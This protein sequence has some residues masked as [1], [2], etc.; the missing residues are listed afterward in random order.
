MSTPADEVP[1][2]AFAFQSRRLAC[3]RCHR[4]KLKCERGSFILSM[5]VATPLGP[6]KRCEKAGVDC[7]NGNATTSSTLSKRKETDSIDPSSNMSKAPNKRLPSIT[8]S[9]SVSP[10][11]E[12]E[13]LVP[14]S[15][16][17]IDSIDSNLTDPTLCLDT[18][19]FDPI[20]IGG[21][22]IDDFSPSSVTIQGLPSPSKFHT[23]ASAGELEMTER[24]QFSRGEDMVESES[25]ISDLL[26]FSATE[27]QMWD[28]DQLLSAA[29]EPAIKPGPTTLMQTLSKLSELQNF[30]F[31]DLGSISKD[32][33]ANAF[34]HSGTRSSH[35]PRTNSRDCD[36]VGKVLQASEYLIDLLTSCA[37]HESP[38]PVP[39]SPSLLR[40][41]RW[42]GSK[43]SQSKYSIDKDLLCADTPL[44]DS[45]GFIARAADTLTTHLDFLRNNGV[46]P[47]NGHPLPSQRRTSNPKV[48]TSLHSS[49]LSPAKLMLLVCYVSLLSVYRSILTSA[50]EIFQASPSPATG[51]R[52]RHSDNTSFHGS[53]I[54][55]QS[56]SLPISSS[57]ILGFR[58]QLE[59][60]TH[61]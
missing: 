60:L 61:T 12:F 14:S 42:E 56:R 24:T 7:T 21:G 55:L 41:D 13:S 19:D 54:P 25:T 23:S 52:Q 3:D 29:I 18:F 27:G 16:P 31:N 48:G 15:G 10:P 46:N 47:S 9:S 26:N 50:F 40:N 32:D 2:F 53:S 34:L 5:G 38:P 6:C 45:F 4:C 30:I 59:V 17:L 39:S 58:M 8:T 44:S 22:S 33:L 11:S 57:T 37:R 43:R 51:P 20:A 49:L 28:K 35:R 1:A 36:L